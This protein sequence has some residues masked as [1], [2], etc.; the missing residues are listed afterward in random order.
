MRRYA[1]TQVTAPLIPSVHSTPISSPIKSSGSLPATKNAK[2]NDESYMDLAHI[3]V[4]PIRQENYDEVYNFNLVG[5]G[6]MI[7][8]FRSEGGYFRTPVVPS[9]SMTPKGTRTK[10]RS[11]PLT[12]RSLTGLLDVA[13]Y[14]GLTHC[15]L[16]QYSSQ[17]SEWGETWGEWNTIYSTTEADQV[18]IKAGIYQ[19]RR[20][21]SR[22]HFAKRRVEL[23]ESAF[24]SKSFAKGQF[25]TVRAQKTYCALERFRKKRNSHEHPIVRGV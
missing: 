25:L 10:P 2:R 6:G 20:V 3:N 22:L 14:F 11:L 13:A 17:K 8:V 5:T 19:V 9:E 18:R 21:Y 16:Q 15:D 12:P 7:F 4:S 24:V 23:V 1:F